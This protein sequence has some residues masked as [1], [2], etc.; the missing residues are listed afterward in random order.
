MNDVELQTVNDEGERGGRRRYINTFS[1]ELTVA[2]W[3][4]YTTDLPPLFHIVAYGLFGT[5]PLSE[6]KL[7]YR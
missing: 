4:I 5:K 3:R 6:P 1:V 7:A 2:Q